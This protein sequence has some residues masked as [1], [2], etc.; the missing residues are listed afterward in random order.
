MLPT[1]R[2]SFHEFCKLLAKN[3]ITLSSIG[4]FCAFP[5]KCCLRLQRDIASRRLESVLRGMKA[6]LRYCSHWFRFQMSW[7]MTC[8][9]QK[10]SS[11][12]PMPLS[13]KDPQNSKDTEKSLCFTIT[14]TTDNNNNGKR[15]TS[16]K[17]RLIIMASM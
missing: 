3:K 7:E 16:R 5:E 2:Q 8:L 15:I 4:S 9:E 1:W 12:C 6:N 10:D 17:I 11:G 14:T 13:Y